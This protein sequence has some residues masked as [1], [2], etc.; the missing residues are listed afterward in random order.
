MA[1]ALNIDLG[2]LPEEPAELYSIAH[3]ANVACGGHTGDRNTMATA[4]ALAKAAGT[5]LSAHPSFFDREGFGR[6]RKFSRPED[7]HDAVYLQCSVL[8]EL[9]AS[10]SLGIRLVKAHGGLYHDAS[11]DLAYATAFLDAVTKAMPQLTTV[12]GSGPLLAEATRSRG[13]NFAAEGFADRRYDDEFRLV[14]RN[15]PGAILQDTDA[16]VSQALM[17]ARLRRFQTLCLHGDSPGALRNARAVS[18][19]L[20]TEGLLAPLA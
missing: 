6:R 16:C 15:E 18:T 13:L 12:I 8:C 14:P 2:E 11:E 9:A 17:L 20:R 1:I 7:V 3:I 10:A 19:A 4:I 5:E